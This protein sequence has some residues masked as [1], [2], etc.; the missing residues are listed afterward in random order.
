[1][2]KK[3]VVAIIQARMESER[4][5]GKVLMELGSKPAIWHIVDRVREAEQVDHIVVAMPDTLKNKE[6]RRSVTGALGCDV[7]EGSNEDVLYRVYMAAVRFDADIIVDITG[8]CPLVDPTHIDILVN[9][10]KNDNVF[11]ASNCHPR[12]WPDGFDV[13]VYTFDAL[14]KVNDIVLDLKHRCH[15]GW[16]IWYNK[17]NLFRNETVTHLPAPP[18]YRYPEWGLTLDTKEDLVVLDMIFKHFENND[19]FAEEVIDYVK[20]HPRLLEINGS[21]KRKTPGEG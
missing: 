8:D 17:Y 11:Y 18:E 19:F 4:L 12:S 20:E 5:P 16:N 10:V 15:V 3:K 1:M 7:F 6:L 2:K 21:V 14:K 13:Q 9:S